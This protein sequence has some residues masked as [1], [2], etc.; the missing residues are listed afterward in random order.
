MLEKEHGP[1]A[2]VNIWDK[3]RDESAMDAI[4]SYLK[5]K[6]SSFAQ[7]QNNYAAWLYF[8]GSRTQGDSYFPEAA[9]YPEAPM[10]YGTEAI[11]ATLYGLRM[12]HVSIDID[13]SFIYRT[14]ING[15]ENDGY[16]THLNN[17][18]MNL[19]AKKFGTNQIF[20]QSADKP[21]IVVLTNPTE[22][23]IQDI[24][25]SIEINPSTP[26]PNPVLVQ[27]SGKTIVFHN[28][29]PNGK[30]SIFSI[31]GRL[32]QHIR[33][34]LT[35]ISPVEWNLSD[36]LGRT[37]SSGIYIYYVKGSDTSSKG[38]FAVVRK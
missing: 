13:K 35:E 22:N 5:S 20:N 7:S 29:P 19:L 12:R 26:S 17:E 28:V 6:N 23:Q 21:L 27:Q 37:V 31:N 1:D 18:G 32:V 4:D 24:T 36:R 14:Q 33:T 15:S 30:I 38:K 25:Y 2:M 11:E 9:V 10:S 34:E 8:T 3:I 16:F